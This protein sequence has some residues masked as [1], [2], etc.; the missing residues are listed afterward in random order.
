MSMA[1][2]RPS[3]RHASRPPI[4]WIGHRSTARRQP[5]CRIRPSRTRWTCPWPCAW[6]RA[7]RRSTSMPAGATPATRPRPVCLIWYC[8]LRSGRACRPC[9]EWRA[10]ELGRCQGFG[11]G[12]GGA[13]AGRA[14]A[15]VRPHPAVVARQPRGGSRGRGRGRI[16][17]HRTRRAGGD[18][19]EHGRRQLQHPA[20]AA[21][22]RA[23]CELH[24]RRHLRRRGRGRE[25]Q[26][27]LDGGWRQ[28]GGRRHPVVVQAL[29]RQGGLH[30]RQRG[31]PHHQAAE[32]LSQCG[33]P[34]PPRPR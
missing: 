13:V 16:A 5:A 6:H 14:H 18:R 25:G 23:G 12:H 34:W 33:E 27:D 10:G 31:R 20:G 26:P 28:G 3:M 29:F 19:P 21:L 22:C 11:A 2:P 24:R 8:R 15:A 32:Q 4:P 30:G 9:A 1:A 7:C 17:R